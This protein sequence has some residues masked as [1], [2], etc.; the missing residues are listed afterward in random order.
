MQGPSGAPIGQFR[1]HEVKALLDKFMPNA[2]KTVFKTFADLQRR[3]IDPLNL[4]HFG[5]SAGNQ[6]LGAR[7]KL[8][9]TEK[10]T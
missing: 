6:Q 10:Y 1:N 8:H 3:V 4:T 9:F 5:S 7:Y 2:G